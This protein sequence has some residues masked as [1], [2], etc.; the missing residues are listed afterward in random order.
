MKLYGAHSEITDAIAQNY[1]Y[2]A[3]PLSTTGYFVPNL[4]RI[5]K[6][7][8]QIFEQSRDF[9]EITDNSSETNF[10]P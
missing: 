1:R 7:T 5:A 9:R 10:Q 6:I 2:E 4:A 3:R 8:E